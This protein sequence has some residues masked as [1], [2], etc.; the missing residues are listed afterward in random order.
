MAWGYILHAHRLWNKIE[1]LT[2]LGHSQFGF[3]CVSLVLLIAINVLSLVLDVPSDALARVT[4][5]S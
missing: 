4:A 5:R 1:A 2:L 3:N